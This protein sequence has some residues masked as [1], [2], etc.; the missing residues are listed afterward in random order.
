M[1]GKPAW[2][3]R[4]AADS[5]IRGNRKFDGCQI[6]QNVN[7]TLPLTFITLGMLLHMRKGGLNFGPMKEFCVTILIE[8][9]LHSLCCAKICAALCQFNVL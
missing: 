9:K 8:I 6:E 1:T 3:G 4:V 5:Q 7:E 2:D